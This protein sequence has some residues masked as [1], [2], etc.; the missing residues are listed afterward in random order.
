MTPSARAI[1]RLPP[2]PRFAQI[3]PTG[4]CNLACRMCTVNHRADEGGMLTLE[5]FERLLDQLPQLEELHLQGLGEPML[6]PQFFEMVELA[7]S[8]GIRVSA[9]TNLTLLTPERAR[10]VASSGLH[11]LSVSIDAAH[12]EV[13][14]AIRLKASFE[15][16]VRNLQRLVQAREEARAVHLHLRLVMVLMRSNLDEL[17]AVLR[18][19]QR[20]GIGEVLVQRLSSDLDQP[21]LPG[22][23]I[24]IRDYVQQAQLTEQ[25]LPRAMQLFAHASRLAAALGVRLH[26]PRLTPNPDA[27]PCTWPWDQLYVTARGDMLPCCMVGTPDRANFGNVLQ[28]GVAVAWQGEA[29]QQF[30]EQLASGTPAQVCQHCAL[31]RGAF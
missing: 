12:R 29:A 23:Y 25:D 19:A 4:S 2:L 28:D 27:R 24:P 15:K 14:E 13:Y 22:R 16:V 3:E 17:A 10:R 21:S 6:N 31:Y 8:R 9:N 30:R 1:D 26:L 5:Q 11:S 18:L 7:V 20:C